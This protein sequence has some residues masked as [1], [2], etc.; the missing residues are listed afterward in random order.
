MDGG[1]G[2]DDYCVTE[3]GS[4]ADTASATQAEGASETDS[5]AK[6]WAA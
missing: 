4:D 5:V 1:S 2:K 3:A 6:R